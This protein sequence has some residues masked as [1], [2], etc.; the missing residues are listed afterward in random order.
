MKLACIVVVLSLT[1]VSFSP[2][3]S[4]PQAPA[5]QPMSTIMG[6]LLDVNDARIVH[7]SVR[8]ENGQFKWVGESDD[9]GDFTAEVPIGRYRIYVDANGFRR[10]ESPFFNAKENTTEMVNLHLEEL[11]IIDRIEVPRKATVIAEPLPNKS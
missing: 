4:R 11:T 1:Y 10:F 5:K 2:A 7:V 3:S 6:T 9:A 8:V